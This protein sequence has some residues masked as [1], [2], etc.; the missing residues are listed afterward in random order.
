MIGDSREATVNIHGQT[1]KLR[2][3]RSKSS[4][5][6]AYGEFNGRVIE[7]HGTTAGNAVLNWRKRIESDQLKS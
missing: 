1:C 7:G 2:V 3:K 5:W 6:I 4:G